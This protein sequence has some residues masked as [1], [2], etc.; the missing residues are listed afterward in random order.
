MLEGGYSMQALRECTEA[1]MEQMELEHPEE[2]QLREDSVFREI[3]R[4]AKTG[5]WKW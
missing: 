2:L 1:I 4:R 3:S 5:F